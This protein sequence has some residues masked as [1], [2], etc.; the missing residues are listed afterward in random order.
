[1]GDPQIPMT[2]LYRM[3]VVMD[4]FYDCSEGLYVCSDWSYWLLPNFTLTQQQPLKEPQDGI[5]RVT[6]LWTLFKE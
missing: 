4:W 2:Q 6:C 3:R 5:A 1:M